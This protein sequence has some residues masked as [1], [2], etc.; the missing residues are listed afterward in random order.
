[1]ISESPHNKQS[2]KETT[3]L[4]LTISFCD[5]SHL[6][7]SLAV[8]QFF[9]SLFLSFTHSK[10]HL[11]L[12]PLFDLFHIKSPVGVPI[13]VCVYS[14]TWLCAAI[15]SIGWTLQHQSKH[16]QG[17][18]YP[19]FLAT[20]IGFSLLFIPNTGYAFLYLFFFHK[21]SLSTPHIPA[22]ELW[23]VNKVH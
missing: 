13:Y 19:S 2:F 6:S 14:F 21:H 8:F 20:P 15:L 22:V 12:S 5:T 1:M 7:S 4:S 10:H 3:S 11:T 17:Y 23:T 9:L 18:S 16:A